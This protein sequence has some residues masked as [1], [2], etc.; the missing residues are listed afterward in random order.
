MTLKF[1]NFIY[2]VKSLNISINTD[3]AFLSVFY[4]F[5]C[6]PLQYIL[7][8][9]IYLKWFEICQTDMIMYGIMKLILYNKI[10]M[11]RN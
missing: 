9:Q 1:K 10:L 3:V 11:I 7:R 2:I 5:Q 6:G 4:T 8:Q